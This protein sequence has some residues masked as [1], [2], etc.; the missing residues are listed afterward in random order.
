MILVNENTLLLEHSDGK[1][2]RFTQ[3]ALG[4][5]Q[6]DNDI[7]VKVTAINENNAR[8]QVVYSDSRTEQFDDQG[9]L[10]L[11]ETLSGLMWTLNHTDTTTTIENTFKN[12]LVYTVNNGLIEKAVIN[13]DKT[14]QYQYDDQKRLIKVT[15]VDGSTRQYHYE[16]SAFPYHLTGITNEQGV[17]YATWDY[18]TQGRGILSKHTDG[19]EKVA[20]EYHD[21][22]STTVTNPLGK[23]TTYYFSKIEGINRVTK[24]EGHASANCAA[25]NREYTYYDNGLL[26][27]KTDWKGV[28][29]SYQYND[30]G[31]LTRKVAASSTTNQQETL[32]E[33]HD[34]FR[35]PTRVTEANRTVHYTYDD[36]GRLTQQTV[37]TDP[38]YSGSTGNNSGGTSGNTNENGNNS[39][40]NNGSSTEQNS[41]NG[42]SNEGQQTNED[43]DIEYVHSFISGSAGY[44]ESVSFTSDCKSLSETSEFRSSRMVQNASGWDCMVIDAPSP[45]E[46]KRLLA[47]SVKDWSLEG[48][49]GYKNWYY[50]Y[51]NYESDAM[52]DFLAY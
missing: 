31:L 46:Q 8:W 11:I 25:A 33:W 10:I 44:D 24:V 38:N 42:Q 34:T 9:R 16:N 37:T 50:G 7:F 45:H 19:A 20:F 47:D 18:D 4:Q 15:L 21:N 49:Q 5:W 36:Q 14:L 3:N 27:S 26:K 40:S 41:N 35:L 13:D 39:S 28:T 51:F 52:L 43:I 22:N 17:R 29:T 2:F 1:T 12:K 30:R 48:K 23:K 6:S 32:T